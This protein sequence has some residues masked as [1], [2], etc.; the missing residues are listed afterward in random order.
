VDFTCFKERVKAFENP[1]SAEAGWL[2]TLS[3]RWFK[4]CDK[5]SYKHPA[6]GEHIYSLAHLRGYI[7]L[8][9]EFNL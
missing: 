1:N 5:P 3:K 7:V 2:V 9:L 8:L 6:T 4:K